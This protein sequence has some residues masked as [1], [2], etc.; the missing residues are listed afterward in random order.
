MCVFFVVV[1]FFFFLG[2]GTVVEHAA[3]TVSSEDAVC[4][5]ERICVVDVMLNSW[6]NN[7]TDF[8]TKELRQ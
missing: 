5:D 3:F 6:D 8:R 1:V 7:C 4:N 2:G